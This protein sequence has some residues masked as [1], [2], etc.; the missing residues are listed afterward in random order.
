MYKSTHLFN[1]FFV[2]A[3]IIGFTL[4]IGQVVFNSTITV[5]ANINGYSNTFAGSLS[6]GYLFGALIGRVLGGKLTDKRSRRAGMVLGTLFFLIAS[7]LFIPGFS[8]NGAVMMILRFLQGFGY[9]CT[10]TAYYVAAVDV[11]PEDKKPIALGINFTGQCIAFVMTSVLISRF[12]SGDSYTMLFVMS[13]AMVAVSVVFSAGMTY[14]NGQ[15]RRIS[16]PEKKKKG[17]LEKEALPYAVIILLYYNAVALPM[18]Y[19]MS[20]ALYKGFENWSGTLIFV[21]IGMF[22]G[23]M[24][25]P[26][27]AYRFSPFFGMFPIYILGC[28]GLLLLLFSKSEQMFIIAGFFYGS[29]I[30]SIPIMQNAAVDHLPDDKKG[31]GTATVQSAVDITMGAGPLLWG[32]LIDCFGF[33]VPFLIGAALYIGGMILHFLVERRVGR[34]PK[35]E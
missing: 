20:L 9:G 19:T 21:G 26:R 7:I 14:E 12:I 25:L 32:I 16:E 34:R 22:T 18:F 28:M 3:W 10:T 6:I 13:A 8:G 35:N 33:K 4:H 15:S 24:I 5:Y 1:K 30:S 11:A 27:I 23:Y 2:F 17:F 31:A 29:A